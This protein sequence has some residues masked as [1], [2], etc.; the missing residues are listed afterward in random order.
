MNGL[1][2][3]PPFR[4]RGLMSAVSSNVA[5]RLLFN[6]PN[7][8]QVCVGVSAGRKDSEGA[9]LVWQAA[10]PT[11][12]QKNRGGFAGGTQTTGQ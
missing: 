5:Y 1:A 2:T 3:S 7:W 4:V 6:W 9:G 12:I 10:L 8:K 11:F